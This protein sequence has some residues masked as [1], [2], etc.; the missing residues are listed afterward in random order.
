[1]WKIL[2]WILGCKKH[3][4]IKAVKHQG[5]SYIIRIEKYEP[6]D[7]FIKKIEALDLEKMARGNTLTGTS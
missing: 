1:M 6:T 2:I 4:F 5:D 3:E 7:V